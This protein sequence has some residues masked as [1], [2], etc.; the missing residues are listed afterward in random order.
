MWIHCNGGRD[1]YL[2]K[3]EN[4]RCLPQKKN[5]CCA[6]GPCFCHRKSCP[7]IPYRDNF[8]PFSFLVLS[9]PLLHQ[10]GRRDPGPASLQRMSLESP[11]ERTGDAVLS[12]DVYGVGDTVWPLKGERA[13]TSLST[14]EKGAHSIIFWGPK[15]FGKK[16]PLKWS[17]SMTSC[18]VREERKVQYSV[19][20]TISVC[21]WG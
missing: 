2:T 12:G 19:G 15:V 5:I 4:L 18:S 14:G 8:Q 13:R 20:V 10:G 17:H 9:A 11:C 7:H 3:C 21:L 16:T 1:Q 6:H